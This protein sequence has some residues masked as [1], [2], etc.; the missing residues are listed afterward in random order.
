MTHTPSAA[1]EP[2]WSDARIDKVAIDALGS[3]GTF[4]FF[5]TKKLMRDVRDD[6]QARIDELEAQLAQAQVGQWVPVAIDDKS[7]II[8]RAQFRGLEAQGFRLCKRSAGEEA[9]IP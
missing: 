6:M 7:N 1:G 8:S 2:L 3:Y 5:D 4:T 9:G